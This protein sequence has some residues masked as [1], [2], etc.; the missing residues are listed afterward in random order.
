MVLDAKRKN[1][2][3]SIL[4]EAYVLIVKQSGNQRVAVSFI[5]RVITLLMVRG[6]YAGFGKN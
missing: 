1:K 2:E 4:D 5:T 3:R 6:K